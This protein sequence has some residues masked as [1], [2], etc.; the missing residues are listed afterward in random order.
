M[1]L[2]RAL[3]SRRSF[4]SLALLPAIAR[5]TGRGTALP[6]AFSRYE[7]AATDLPVTRLTDPAITSFLPPPESSSI[8]R[9]GNTMLYAADVSGRLEVYRMD[10]KK[11]ESHQVT[12]AE[13]LHPANFSLLPDERG[14]CYVD[15][16][17]LMTSGFS[18][19][20]AMQVYKIPEGFEAGRGLHLSADGMYAALIERRS[21]MHRLQLIAMRTGVASTLAEAAEEI[22]APLT[23]PKRASV[24]YR[25]A[26]DLYLANFDGKQNY[27]LRVAEGDA[28][29]TSWSPEGRSL[30]Y[31]NVPSEAGKLNSIREFVP[32]TNED[33]PV[34][35]TTQFAGFARNSDASVFVGAS[36]SKASPYVLL[37]V[38]AVKR[39]LTLC[40]HRASNPSM[41]APIFSPNSQQVFFGS[42]LHGKPAIYRM[43]V[44]K[45]VS[46]T[47]QTD[48]AFR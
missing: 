21:A 19:A 2:A 1:T 45:L 37:L 15:G 3:P 34:A 33:R 4:L 9:R 5:A 30:L 39:E 41:V 8:A 24:L 7:D 46:D 42:D 14:L 6:S 13:M 38:R 36:G 43:D 22:S 10:L 17:R 32:D 11:G 47:A 12:E 31:L 28:I 27:R 26:G 18:A 44:E 40:E 48:G 25:R 35:D 16:N 20:K 29:Q 23:R